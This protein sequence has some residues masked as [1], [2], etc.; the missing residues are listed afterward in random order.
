MDRVS[1]TA[2]VA[3]N[4]RAEMEMWL[5]LRSHL[6]G[7]AW[8]NTLHQALSVTW[9]ADAS[10]SSWGVVMRDPSGV[11][12]KAAGDFPGEMVSE[13]INVKEAYAGLRVVTAILQDTTP[14]S[15]RVHG[16]GRRAQHEG[17]PRIQKNDVEECTTSRVDHITEIV[18]GKHGFHIKFG[19][20]GRRR[21][22]TS[23]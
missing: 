10:S 11:A 5:E 9:A 3:G 1:A 13:H 7:A 4:L 16:G 14:R 23:G 12:F 15:Q 21:K 6:N 2:R 19:C 18:A 8:Y 20:P 22:I 17:I